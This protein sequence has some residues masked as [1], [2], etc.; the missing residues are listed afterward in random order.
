[1]ASRGRGRGRGRGGRA[2]GRGATTAASTDPWDAYSHEA[3][4]GLL[5]A[6]YLLDRGFS[7]TYVT[8]T[9]EAEGML[10][11]IHQVSVAWREQRMPWRDAARCIASA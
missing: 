3:H 4:V 5:V 2:K 9:K 10:H 6:Q 8:F 1:M 11:G 7:S